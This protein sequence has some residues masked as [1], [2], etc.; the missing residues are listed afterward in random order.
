MPRKRLRIGLVDHL[1]PK[2]EL[3]PEALK[4]AQEIAKL[5]PRIVEDAKRAVNMAM[6]TPLDAGL[7]LETDICL[8]AGSGSGFGEDAKKFKNK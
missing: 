6:S 8:G 4:L 3:I 5:K 1:Y 2:D 7:R